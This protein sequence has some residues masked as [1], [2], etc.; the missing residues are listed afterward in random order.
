MNPALAILTLP[1]TLYIFILLLVSTSFE[2]WQVY[3][4]YGQQKHIYFEC[5]FL[6]HEKMKVVQFVFFRS[7]TPLHLYPPEIYRVKMAFR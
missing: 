2:C 7:I 4:I 1:A 5:M 6:F 3:G